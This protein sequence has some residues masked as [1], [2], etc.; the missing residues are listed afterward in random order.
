MRKNMISILLVLAIIFSMNTT[1]FAS[2]IGDI[3]ANTEQINNT[4]SNSNTHFSTRIHQSGEYL[5]N[6]SGVGYYIG[7]G[8]SPSGSV[9]NGCC[10]LVISRRLVSG[11]PL[12]STSIT[13]KVGGKTYICGVASQTVTETITGL[14]FQDVSIMYEISG[15]NVNSVAWSISL[16]CNN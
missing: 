16:R 11:S 8:G 2:E 15:S 7:S 6:K 3:Q 5:I 4:Y 1:V 12:T 14:S 9:H 13:V 10:T